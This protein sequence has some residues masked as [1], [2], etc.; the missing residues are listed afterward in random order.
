MRLRLI[1]VDKLRSAPIR[2][3]CEDFSMRLQPYFPCEIVEVRAADGRSP[4]AAIG[5]EGERILR[6]ARDD[7]QL[8]LLD[9]EGSAL[10]SVQLSERI[11][12]LNATGI[13]RLTLV[14]AGTYGASPA[15]QMR[16]NF[17]WSL[18]TLTFLH[19][20]ARALVLEQLY[21]AAK[22]ARNEPYHH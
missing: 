15:L 8:W 22:I 14:V 11:D 7:E 2:A 10:S 18:S 5:E 9:R 16:A 3:L 1:A 21:R 13:S 4:E 17:R 19:E 12:G 20:W 6:L